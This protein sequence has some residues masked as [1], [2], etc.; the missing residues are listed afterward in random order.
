MDVL[1]SVLSA[2]VWEEKFSLLNYTRKR[3]FMYV[4]AMTLKRTIS[5]F[6]TIQIYVNLLFKKK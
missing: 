6:L 4:H 2:S 5:N 1:E 3:H